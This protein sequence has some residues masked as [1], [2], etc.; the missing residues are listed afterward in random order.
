MIFD[1]SYGQADVIFSACICLLQAYTYD[2]GTHIA[3]CKSYM[4]LLLHWFPEDC[5]SNYFIS[6]CLP[7]SEDEDPE[8]AS[9]GSGKY[10]GQLLQCIWYQLDKLDHRSPEKSSGSPARSCQLCK[11][12]Q[13][14][15]HTIMQ[16]VPQMKHLDCF[17]SHTTSRLWETRN[18]LTQW[19]RLK[20]KSSS[21]MV[22]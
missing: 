11:R 18:Q 8:E 9:V 5:I 17:Y 6:S 14:Y 21:N 20:G 16:S 4:T 19:K 13:N 22:F 1:N 10:H 3:N 15:H 12:E 2:R 7:E